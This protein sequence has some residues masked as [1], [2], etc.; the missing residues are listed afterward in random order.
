MPFCTTRL[1]TTLRLLS[2]FAIG[3]VSAERAES[4]QVVFL[5]FARTGGDFEVDFSQEARDL[6]QA[7]IEKDYAQFDFSFVQT[8]PTSGDYSTLFFNDGPGFGIAQEIDFR[9][10]NKNDTATIQTSS[11]FDFDTGEI[12]E[13][14]DNPRPIN[15]NLFDNVEDFAK[16]SAYVAS[17]ELGHI[18]G[19]RHRD[20]LGPIGSGFSDDF[21]FLF[22]AGSFASPAYPGPFQATDTPNHLMETGISQN[23][24]TTLPEQYFGAR[25]AIKL[26]FNERGSVVPEAAGFKPTMAT[27]QALTLAPLDVPNTIESGDLVGAEFFVNAVAVTGELGFANERDFYSFEGQAGQVINIEVI[28]DVFVETRYQERIDPIITLYDSNGDIV[29]YYGTDA[30]NDDEFETFDAL[31]LDLFLPEDDTYFIEIDA[32][33]TFDT[34]NY[35]LFIHNYRFEKTDTFLDQ[36]FLPFDLNNDNF[37]NAADYTVLR[38]LFGDTV[39]PGS[40]GDFDNNGKIDELD[41]EKW[42]LNYGVAPN[43][44]VTEGPVQLPGGGGPTFPPSPASIPEPATAALIVVTLGAGLMSRCRV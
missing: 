23:M 40:L 14:P 4:T 41:L 17:H 30:T 15:P 42:Q 34:G 26:S 38:D 29:D 18:Q 24:I 44:V 11:V 7:G 35:E 28:S 22:G 8:Q 2:I 12:I 21:F 27:A 6:I 33:Q 37:I 16:F 39:T 5:D 31:I 32:F 25:E 13:D 43:V 9:N 3:F 20:S 36:E 19:L 10:V 1:L